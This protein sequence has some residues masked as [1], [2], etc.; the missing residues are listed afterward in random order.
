[1]FSLT[2]TNLHYPWSG[3]NYLTREPTQ[4]I[5]AGYWYILDTTKHHF[6]DS[7]TIR[8][9]GDFLPLGLDPKMRKKTT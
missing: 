7:G 5:A 6:V 1:M 2:A 9:G 3:E 4:N 8:Y